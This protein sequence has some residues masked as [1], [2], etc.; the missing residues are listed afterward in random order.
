EVAAAMIRSLGEMGVD[1]VLSDGRKDLIATATRRAQEGLDAAHSG[2]TLVSLELTEL[3]PP[4]ALA[5]DFDAVQSAYIEMETQKKN[6]EAYAQGVVPRAHAEADAAVQVA[7]ADA[8]AAL[9]RARGDAEAFRA[10]DRQVRANPVVVYERLYRD[11]VEKAIGAAQKVHWVPPP[12]GKRYEGTR[13]E[14][15]VEKA[16]VREAAPP[17]PEE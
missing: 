12:A 14:V 7:R 15:D 9:A 3:R 1:H 8:A 10:L 2:L 4:R 5:A 11:A 16:G 17:L 13:I 6:A